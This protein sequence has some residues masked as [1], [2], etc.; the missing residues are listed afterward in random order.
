MNGLDEPI[1]KYFLL[2]REHRPNPDG[3]FDL[4]GVFDGFYSAEFPYNEYIRGAFGVYGLD[5]DQEHDVRIELWMDGVSLGGL[6][7]DPIRVAAR[8]VTLNFSMDDPDVEIPRVGTLVFR[9]HID[10]DEVATQYV[11][12]VSEGDARAA[13]VL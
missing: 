9:I 3:G 1:L 6:M 11:Q 7:Y 5:P 8:H 2:F 4:L 10:G 12:V 13:G